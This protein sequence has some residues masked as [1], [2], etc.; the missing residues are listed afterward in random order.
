MI[1]QPLFLLY[2]MDMEEKELLHIVNRFYILQLFY[3]KL[4]KD[5]LHKNITERKCY[6]VDKK[7]ALIKGFLRTDQKYQGKG[8]N[9]GTCAVVALLTEDN[10]LWVANVGDSRCVLYKEGKPI[11]LSTDHKPSLESERKRIEAAGH[12]VLK[13][14][15]LVNG[16]RVFTFRVDGETA[17]S[18]SI[19]DFDYKDS[20]QLGAEEQAITSYPEIVVEQVGKGQFFVLACD[21]V[22]DVMTN[23]DVG[24]YIISQRIQELDMN[25]IALNLA[26]EAINRG[27]SDNIT[28]IVVALD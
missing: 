20:Y 18:R 10:R 1:Q 2:T 24:N 17:V 21:G 14:T 15:E 23:E 16:K 27:S 9:D 25:K 8:K 4:G 19:G 13:D 28:V 5:K 12:E 26:N 6:K 22:W 11:P 3:N 7:S